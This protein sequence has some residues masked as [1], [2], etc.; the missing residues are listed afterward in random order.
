VLVAAD[1]AASQASWGDQQSERALAST[2]Y[3]RSWGGA[4]DC[5]LAKPQSSTSAGRLRTGTSLN[6]AL[7]AKVVLEVERE[8]GIIK[9]VAAGY[10]AV[11]NLSHKQQVTRLY[12]KSL[13]L[14]ESWA[15]DREVFLTE[16]AKVRQRF[17]ENKHLDPAGGRVARLLRE[18]EEEAAKFFH[19]DPYTVPY[20]PGGS[21]FM[22][23]P[24]PPLELVFQSV[25]EIP[26]EYYIAPQTVTCV[27]VSSSTGTLPLAAPS[28]APSKSSFLVLLFP[29]VPVSA[30]PEG[31]KKVLID[32]YT[33]QYQ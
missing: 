24:P 30:E 11:L 28:Y 19:P 23:N 18:G 7:V 1:T 5:S 12:R 17:D 6:T 32:V 21:K 3:E 14:I 9:E 15:G 26:P 20:M 29:Q 10:K 31:P 8:M 2:F 33:K 22:R 25:G 4:I 13:K 16:A 27:Q